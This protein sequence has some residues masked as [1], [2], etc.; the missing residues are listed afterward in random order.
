[1][2]TLGAPSAS[3]AESAAISSIVA[4]ILS[5]DVSSREKLEQAKKLAA[6]R[7]HLDKFLSNSQIYLALSAE[8]REGRKE[9]FRVHPRRSAS[10]IVIVTVFTAPDHCPHGT[11][12]YCPGGPSMGTPQSYVP[13]GPS[14]RGAK[15]V[16]FDPYLQAQKMLKKYLDRGHEA[17]KV[18]LMVE[19]GTF[20]ADAR[21]LPGVVHQ[22]RL[23]WVELC[24][25]PIA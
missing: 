1:M 18:E 4:S 17:S 23:R 13:D 8:E 7:F 9:I 25:V 2:E 21:G 6:K 16:N 24:A 11:C 12:V 14:M 20:L 3:D 10:G 5:G 19:G 15:G 22:R